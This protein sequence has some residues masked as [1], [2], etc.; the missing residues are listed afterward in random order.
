VSFE[1]FGVLFLDIGL[2]FDQAYFIEEKF[3]SDTRWRFMFKMAAKNLGSITVQF[4][5]IFAFSLLE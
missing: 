5:N 4:G 1:L 3:L 2:Y